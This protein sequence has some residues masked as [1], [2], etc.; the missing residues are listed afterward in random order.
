MT[1]V[2]YTTN[3][4][5]E[6]LRLAKEKAELCDMDGANA[7]IEAALRLY[8]A[9]C[10]TQVWEKTMQGGWIKKMIVRSNQV[11]F[12]SIR[13]RKV[14]ERYNPKYFTDEVLAPKGWTK[15]WKMK[16]G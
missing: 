8:F 11:I 4:D 13:V 1:R 14:K 3:L 7:V 15:V 10:S 12:E 16:Q 2:K 5:E 6:L 9:N